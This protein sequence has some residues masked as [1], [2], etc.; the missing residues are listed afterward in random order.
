MFMEK[1]DLEKAARHFA[2]VI[3]IEPEFGDAHFNL[4]VVRKLLLERANLE[5]R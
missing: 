1:G 2:K 3:E 4:G 5:K